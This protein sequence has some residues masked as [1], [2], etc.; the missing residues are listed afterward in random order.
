MLYLLNQRFPTEKAY[1]IQVAKM[2]EAFSG[3][4]VDLEL[5]APYRVNSSADAFQYYSIKS[6]F[7]I[8]KVFSPDFYLPGK[9]DR[10]SFWIKNFIS[11]CALSFYALRSKTESIYSR[12][13]LPLY[14]L[15][16]LSRKNLVFEAHGFSSKRKL[17]YSRFNKRGVK[18]VAITNGIKKDFV[19]FSYNPNLVLVAHD[20]VDLEE[21]NDL[22]E[23]S[24]LK[25]QAGLPTDKSLVL[26]AG[27]LYPR[28]GASVLAQAAAFYPQAAFIFVGGSQEDAVLFKEKFGH[29]DNIFIVGQRAHREALAFM[30]MADILVLPNR[31]ESGH[32]SPLKLF[33]YMAAGKPIIASD[34]ASIR[35]ILNE[36]NAVLVQPGNPRLIAEA[37]ERLLANPLAASSM[38]LRAKE[39]VKKYDWQARARAIRDFAT[40]ANS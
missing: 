36:S 13:E 14:L 23:P 27:Q 8:T 7:K 12:E 28:K 4:G 2:C 19:S 9:L 11:A 22:A 32:T 25:E 20:G 6:N 26:Y 33:E 3:I 21:F 30:V 37:I 18:V 39:D 40:F 31:Q 10:I 38:A 29:T 34:T 16:F 5:V 15:S 1:G 35:E 24:K 17:F